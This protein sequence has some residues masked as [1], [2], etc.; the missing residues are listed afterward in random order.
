MRGET[1]VSP[2]EQA[3]ESAA[4]APVANAADVGSVAVVEDIETVR[5]Q[6]LP[7]LGALLKFKVKLIANGMLDLLLVP[8][9]LLAVGLG[10]AMGGSDPGRYFRELM[11]FGRR[12]ERWIN[13]F[14]GHGNAGR[15][16][17]D[18]LLGS[19]ED[20]VA[21]IFERRGWSA[22]TEAALRNAS[23]GRAV[24]KPGSADSNPDAQ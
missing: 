15:R 1:V 21:A 20:E 12:T 11:L 6:R 19:Y 8:A 4:H 5:Y 17:I 7:L 3:R 9:S 14:G 16:G 24:A 18:A 23:L 10:M 2:N 22:P 13:L